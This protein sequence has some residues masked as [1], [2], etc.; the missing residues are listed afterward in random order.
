MRFNLFSSFPK[1]YEGGMSQN[2][3]PKDQLRRLTMTCL[4]WEDN[5][6]I[7]GK[8]AA[9]LIQSTC[10]LLE[11]EIIVKQA[12]ECSKYGK[13]R[14]IPLLL[15]VA[16]LKKKAKCQEAIYEI[17]TRPDQMTE[18][19]SLYWKV[20]GKNKPIAAQ[21]KKGL[22]KAFTRYDAYQLA[23]YNRDAPIKLKD[24]LFL[25]HP[26]PKN[27]DQQRDWDKLVKGE[28]AIPD[29][30]ETRLSAGKDK[31]ETFTTLLQEN[32]LGKLALIRNL[33]NMFEVGVDKQLV[34]EKLIGNDLALLPF[35]FL[36]AAKHCPTWEDI[37]DESMI[38]SM[39]G[40][41]KLQGN[42]VILVDRSGSMNNNLSGKSEA[43]RL[44]AACGMAILL[45]ECCQNPFIFTFSNNV[46]GIPSRSG[47]ALREAIVNSQTGGAT[48]L[49]NSIG[50]I[51]QHM[52]SIFTVI[53][54][55]IVI[56]DEQTADIIPHV[57]SNHNYI[58][59]VAP[60]QNGVAT[61]G[62]WNLINGFSESMVDYIRE[63]E[64]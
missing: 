28:L 64:K 43:T 4:L 53:D 57:K 37:I 50:I 47:M 34:K 31:K 11:G 5:F 38:Q 23:K 39:K 17:C 12:I 24:V 48:Y 54:R 36:N 8:S 62:Q 1:T 58:M 33:R 56:T 26:K 2:I 16:A 63:F 61:N 59:N 21:L 40:I 14:H 52:E 19:L 42:T 49:G 41:E 55:F 3:S 18:L 60:Y 6:Y 46:V 35:Q 7:D 27:E 13:L 22:A 15:I 10:A 25:V 29:T 9:D 20:N 51:N 32:K 44:D 30:W 45:K